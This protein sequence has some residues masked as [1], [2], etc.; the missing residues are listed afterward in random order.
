MNSSEKMKRGFCEIEGHKIAYF[1]QGSGDVVL[2]VHGIT[3]YS[4]MWRNI[5]NSLSQSYDV[6]ALDLLGCGDS[7]KPL[8]V[9]YS[10]K[11][12]ARRIRLFVDALGIE[13]F[14]L[15]GHD[16]GGGISQIYA[17]NNPNT[18]TDLSLI[19]SVSFDFWPVQPITAMRTPMIRHLLMASLDVGTFRLLVRRGMYHKNRV[20][21]ELMELFWEPMKTSDGRKAFLHFAR[22]LNN[23]DLVE[24]SDQLT[25][26]DVKT[27]IIRGD[28]DVYL[29][30]RSTE[31]LHSAI[32]G[33]RL[34]RFETGGHF[35]HED[36]PDW[37]SAQ[38][39]TF[40]RDSSEPT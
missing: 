33:S 25:N 9:P 39:E 4:F 17:V 38:L 37:L 2:L 26:L 5:A 14:H 36:A 34:V 31:R 19:N 15:V 21:P 30:A 8:D 29:P 12:H 11:E 27:L 3:T 22:S 1:R 10:I 13:K 6:I 35:I 20:S 23:N 40:F 7:D 32:Q 28:A 16:L 24:I 18:L